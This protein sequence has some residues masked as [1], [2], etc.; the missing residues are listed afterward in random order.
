MKLKSLIVGFLIGV[1]AAAAA[2]WFIMPDM[3]LREH[4]SPLSVEETVEQIKAAALAEGW[5]VSSVVPLDDSVK[6]N[7]GGHLP[8]VRLI[9]LCRADHAFRILEEDGNK[10]VSVMMPCTISVYEKTD[11]TTYVGTMNAGLLGNMFGGTIAYVM[12]GDVAR[13]Q[14]QFLSFLEP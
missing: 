9:N 5:V 3:M 2:G 1:L 13:Q 4:P 11:G 12:G 8:K 6:K 7:G 14:K 10:K